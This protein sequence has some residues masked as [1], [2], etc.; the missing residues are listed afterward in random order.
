MLAHFDQYPEFAQSLITDMLVGTIQQQRDRFQLILDQLTTKFASKFILEDKV[1]EIEQHIANI[2]TCN[3]PN[4]IREDL[5][6]G[7]V[8]RLKHDCTKT[9]AI[10][11]I[12]WPTKTR[13]PITI[14]IAIHPIT[15]K[16]YVRRSVLPIGCNTIRTSHERFAF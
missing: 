4:I 6:N 8:K 1:Q 3:L 15:R 10:L 5:H 2:Y 12:K 11:S 14:R 13:A 7:P 16:A 9:I